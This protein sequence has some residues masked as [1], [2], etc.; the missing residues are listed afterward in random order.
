MHRIEKSLI[1]RAIE[2][3]GLDQIDDVLKA[4]ENTGAIAYTA[5]RAEEEAALARQQ[6]ARFPD[7]PH[8]QA[9]EGLTH[10]AVARTH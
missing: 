4:I 3:G 10:F 8:L 2:N 9:L 1:K 6:L 5:R 7:S